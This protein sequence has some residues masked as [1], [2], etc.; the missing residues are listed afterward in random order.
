M[1][2]DGELVESGT[3]RVDRKRALE[4]LKEFQFPDPAMFLL[5]WIR[6]AVAS[7]ATKITIQIDA[8]KTHLTMSFD[9]RPFGEG[10]L[11]DPYGCLL[12]E[13]TPENARNRH[14]AVGILAALRL[15]P[16]KLTVTSG[17]DSER[18]CLQ[19]ESLEQET[20]GEAN[21]SSHGTVLEVMFLDHWMNWKAAL[22]SVVRRYPVEFR[23]ARLKFTKPAGLQKKVERE[24]SPQERSLQYKFSDGKSRGWVEVPNDTAQSLSTIRLYQHRVLVEEFEYEL[25]LVSV[26]IVASV[27]NDHFTL[28]ASQSGVVRDKHFKATM[29]IVANQVKPLLAQVGRDQAKT[30]KSLFRAHNKFNI[31]RRNKAPRLSDGE[32]LG[33]FLALWGAFFLPILG[34][35]LFATELLKP[36]SSPSTLPSEDIQKALRGTMWV[37]KACTHL[38]HEYDSDRTT[39]ERKTLW[40]TPI[41]LGVD[42]TPLSLATLELQRRK[43]GSIPIS[44]TRR[45]RE[46]R[47]KVVWCVAEE[48]RDD[49]EKFFPGQIWD[50]TL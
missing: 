49:L 12:D 45:G 6:C 19:I 11:N 37:R 4:K 48:D 24:A 38:L 47:K 18:R 50:I 35:F 26:P 46:T 8:A 25:P 7:G 15:S 9:G 14:L 39:P 10:E 5:P 32:N 34:V 43:L 21:E 31:W 20:L 13:S 30:L 16:A 22:E 33:F 28:N 27:N 17:M 2:E 23:A 1:T 42:G 36:S 41:F 44:T 29:Q 40:E 3:F